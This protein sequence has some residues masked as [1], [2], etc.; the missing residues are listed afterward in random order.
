MPLLRAESIEYDH[1]QTKF[2]AVAELSVSGGRLVGLLGPNGAGKSTLLRVLAGLLTPRSGVVYIC[3]HRVETFQVERR[4][5]CLAWVPQ[6]AET[7]FEWTVEEMVAIGRHP[8]LGGRLRD[9]DSDRRVVQS[10][11][12]HVG[13]QALSHRSVSTLSGGEWQRALIARALTQEP[14]V[15]LLDEPVA[16]L[17]LA[18][19]R[20]IYELIQSLCRDH[21]MAVVAADHHVDLQ[22]QFCDELVLLD[23]GKVR[24]Q[25]S[26]AE[27]LTVEILESVYRTPLRVE[28]DP[29]TGRPIV[30]WRFGSSGIGD[31]G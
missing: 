25:G 16:N 11:L 7:P 24:A 26:P 10:A 5:R 2:L 20:Q 22:A 28:N 3:G 17:D 23:R 9:R 27:V 6:K 15:L 31:S 30:H 4:A 21:G 1:G 19:Q 8:H 13:L 12:D 18:Y 14:Q 29:E